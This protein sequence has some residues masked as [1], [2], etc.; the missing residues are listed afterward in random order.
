MSNMFEILNNLIAGIL[1]ENHNYA[2]IALTGKTTNLP[3]KLKQ[4]YS[5]NSKKIKEIDP[6]FTKE[7][8]L[9]NLHM[10]ICNRFHMAPDQYQALIDIV[11]SYGKTIKIECGSLDF[12]DNPRSKSLVIICRDVE[13][14]E[15]FRQYI[16]QQY[17]QLPKEKKKKGGQPVIGRQSFTPHIT[18]AQTKDCPRWAEFKGDTFFEGL[19]VSFNRGLIEMTDESI[20]YQ[21]LKQP[22]IIP[23]PQSAEEPIEQTK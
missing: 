16:I 2:S 9:N 22:E 17:E 5:A 23:E 21:D 19:K 7:K 20:Y 12:F 14:L 11:K 10:T 3:N 13:N 6:T 15:D 8:Y 4:W 1:L 18:I